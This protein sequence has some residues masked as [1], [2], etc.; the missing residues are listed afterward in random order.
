MQSANETFLD[1][2][3]SLVLSTGL[4][5]RILLFSS[6]AFKMPKQSK[7]L[8]HLLI[9]YGTVD[10]F[11]SVVNDLKSLR[12]HKTV[13]VTGFLNFL[14][15]DRWIRIRTYNYHPELILEAQKLTDPTDNCPQRN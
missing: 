13:E 3:G 7:F 11:K 12:S 8:L 5:I 2:S 6:V 10:T 9:T 14:L 15:F 1:G 4:H